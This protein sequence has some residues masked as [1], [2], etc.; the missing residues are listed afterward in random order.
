MFLLLAGGTAVDEGA[1]R[2]MA[3]G[4]RGG[5]DAPEAWLDAERRAG[6]A[7]LRP[8]FLPEDQFDRQPLVSAERVF[9]CQARLDNREA[10]LARLGVS[11]Q[12]DLA[13]SEVL[14]RAYERWGEQC[15]DH[16]VGDYA[17]AAWHRADGRVVAAVDPIGMRR[18]YWAPIGGGIALS[19]QLPA[20][21]AH[22]GVPRE[23]DLASLARLLDA[24][25]DRTT[26]PFAGLSSLPGGHLLRWRAGDAR[27]ERWWHP[28][29]APTVWHRDPRDYREEV[30]ELFTAAVSA[31]LRS[32]G[33]VS[34]MLSGGLDSG[35]VTAMAARLLAPAGGRV[36][37]YTAV[38]EAGLTLS[39]RPN[40]EADDRAY[41]AETAALYPNVDHRL[42]PPGGRSTLEA[43]RDVFKRSMT[44]LKSATNL[45]WLD[46][47]GRASAYAGS[48]VLL[49]GQNGN[50]LFSARGD[51]GVWELARLGRIGAALAQIGLEA[52]GA[53]VSRARIAAGAAAGGLRSAFPRSLG[54]GMDP[55]SRKFIAAPRRPDRRGRANE[56]AAVPG[57]RHYWATFATT[58]RNIFWAEPV[59]Q[60]GIEWRDP[61][62]DRRLVERLLTYPQAAFRFEGRKRGL[63]R[64][65][66]ESLL[67][68]RVRLRGTQGAQ[69]PEAPSLIAAHWLH[70]R[71]ALAAMRGSAACRELLDL[72]AMESGLAAFAGG[73]SQGYL[74]ALA[75]DRAFNVGTFLLHVEDAR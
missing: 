53:K 27:I 11:D 69:V 40:W 12:P 33:P 46:A 29:F 30:R 48:N 43:A 20:L 67:P 3:R 50:A 37:A 44:P 42:V 45:L 68:D 60:W 22:P 65:V 62:A 9:V 56:Y 10:L 14:A 58:P 5:S 61:T 17:F 7:A 32:A 51:N 57:T 8:Y 66:A 47:I 4:L 70:Y 52:E 15:V 16:L 64:G 31:Q 13:D 74:A 1:L 75:L 54:A 41:A 71:E 34:A 25:I 23:P 36:A 38:P 63:A 24:G 26:T 19:A 35:C 59:L 72:Q 6:A 18:L 28:A 49:V 55:P 73:G 21:L 39:Q 2:A